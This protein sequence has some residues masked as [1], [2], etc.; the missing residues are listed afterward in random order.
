MMTAST[1]TQGGTADTR[2][3]RGPLGR[4]WSDA[5][6]FLFFAALAAWTVSRMPEVGILLLPT[7]A[8]ET[9]VAVT[10]LLR[11]PSKANHSNPAARPAAYAGTFLLLAFFHAAR[12]WKPEWL[13]PNG[14]LL[15]AEGGTL[16]WLAGSLLVA[17]SIW[18]L[19]S[20]FSIEPEARRI[21]RAGP[22]KLVRHPIY[23]GYVLQYGG[24]WLIYPTLGLAAILA[25]WLG[26]TLL[27]IQFEEEVLVRTFPEYEAY[28]HSIDAIVP[29]RRIR[30]G[31]LTA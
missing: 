19:R 17:I 28:R 6:G 13:R 25:I 12:S 14:S 31:A 1:G 8:H 26:L 16:L 18:F 24:L 27:R 15:V 23:L 30:R 22:Y 4:S 5:A 9:F 3:P 10:F 29:L 20:S 11:D 7:L 2:V 21:V